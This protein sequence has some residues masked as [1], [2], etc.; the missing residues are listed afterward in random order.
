MRKTT[1]AIEMLSTLA[2]IDHDLISQVI[3]NILP[4]LLLVRDTSHPIIVP[5]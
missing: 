2:R 5:I 1:L 4:K 3:P